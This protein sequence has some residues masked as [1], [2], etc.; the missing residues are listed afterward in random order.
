MD[1]VDTLTGCTD[2]E[3]M[4]KVIDYWLQNHPDDPTWTEIE[5]VVDKLGY[6]YENKESY[7]VP[8]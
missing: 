6:V 4:V 2:S 7:D 1:F 8:G 3:C 5:T